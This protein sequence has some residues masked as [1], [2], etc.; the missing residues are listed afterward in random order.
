MDDRITS[1]SS[2]A[3]SI[4]CRGMLDERV[5]LTG[6]KIGLTRD[7]RNDGC[8]ISVNKVAGRAHVGTAGEIVRR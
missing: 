4:L 3:C 5:R 7:T 1:S 6:K 2:V 8:A